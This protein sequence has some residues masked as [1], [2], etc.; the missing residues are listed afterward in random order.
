[1]LESLDARRL[2]CL[3]VKTLNEIFTQIKPYTQLP[4]FLFSN[5]PAS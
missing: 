5:L 4:L 3:E 1:M 2:G